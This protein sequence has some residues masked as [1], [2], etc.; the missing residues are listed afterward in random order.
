VVGGRFA[1]GELAREGGMGVVHQARDAQTGALVAIKV[2]SRV[3]ELRAQRF[4][5]EIAIL[6]QL[7]HPGIVRYLAHGLTARG[8][9]FLAMEWLEGEDLQERLRRGPLALDEAL[10]VL[11]CACDALAAA[12]ARGI[13]HRDVKP[14]NLFLP[15]EQ[16]GTVKLLDFG[17]ARSAE[18][19]A[20]LTRAGEFLGTVGYIAPEQAMGRSEIGASADVFAL[21]CVLYEC[22]TGRAPFESPHPVAVL[23]KVLCEE[24]LAPSALQPALGPDYD[25][26]LR[27]ALAKEPSQRP[28][29]AAAFRAELALLAAG[30]KLAARAAPE[31][32][33]M[34]HAE[35]KIVSV[36]LGRAMPAQRGADH[37]PLATLLEEE[38]R[39]LSLNFSAEVSPLQGGALLLVFRG[40]GE[41]N[42]RASQAAQC[43]L[44]LGQLRPELSLAVA[45]G[46]AETSG[47]IPVGV[48]IDRAAALL[49]DDA[50]SAGSV[51]VDELTL[52][53]AGPRFDVQRVQGRNVLRAL[54]GEL[55]VARPLLGK[56]TPYLGRDTEL[57]LLDLA[58]EECLREH[59]ARTV[60]VSGA[61]G[62]GKSRLLSEWLQRPR[63]SESVRVSIARAEP[64]A[65]GAGLALM[66]SLLRQAARLRDSEPPAAQRARLAEHLRALLPNGTGEVDAGGSAR[67]Q[68]VDAGGSAREQNQASWFLAELLD[69]PE[70]GAPAPLLKA[71]RDNPEIMREQTRRAL[72]SWF[73]AELARGPWLVV[74]EDLH[75]GDAPSVELIVEALTRAAQQPLCL[76]VLARP[77]LEQLYPQLA[78]KA[79]LHIRVPGLMPRAAEGLVR[80]V[81][82]PPPPADVI[83]N[84]VRTAD[85]NAFYLEELIRHVAAGGRDL[86]ETVLAMVQSRLEHL[87]PG[88]RCVLRAASV[89]GETFWAEGV[90]RIV[91]TGID[92]GQVLTMLSERE[93]VVRSPSCRYAGAR[94]YRFRHALLRDAANGMLTDRDREHAHRVAGEWLEACGEKEARLLGEHFVAGKAHERAIPWLVRASRAAIDHGDLRGTIEL[95]DRGL[96]LGV[97]G[98]ERALLL[99]SRA[100]AETWSGRSDLPGL[101]EALAL[102]PQGSA[103]WWL[104]I[105]LLT[106][107]E[108]AAGRPQE[109]A[110]YVHAALQAPASEEYAGSFGQAL[111]ILVGALVLLGRG[112]LCATLIARAQAA[113]ESALSDPIYDAFLTAARCAL[114]SVAQIAGRWQL[115]YAFRTG[116]AVAQKMHAAGAACGEAM[117]LSYFAVAATH[118]GRYEEAEEACRRA[119]A[120]AEH[121]GSGLT[122]DWAKVFLAKAQVRIGKHQEAAATLSELYT[123]GD[124]NLR[125]MLPA[126]SG[127]ALYRQGRYAQAIADAERTVAG[128]SPRLRRM[129]GCLRARAELALGRPEQA[130][131]A[132]EDALRE[133]T[134]TGLDSEIDL[135]TVCAEARAA[136]GDLA[137]A[138][139]A[140]AQARALIAA[141]AQ[142]IEDAALRQSFLERVEPCARAVQL[143]ARLRPEPC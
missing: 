24:P 54:K 138:R 141:V 38:L 15:A 33:R 93:I 137:G 61:P 98:S 133:Q 116:G 89:F 35:Q 85:G 77:E 58:L 22:L 91:E 135:F 5:R 20:A 127:E 136:L 90:A 45:T 134:S 50:V 103:P 12:H 139:A 14:N 114:A 78:R 18:P 60:L 25:D 143:G 123:S 55:E 112:E 67:E 29:D 111:L 30:K 75:W 71:A 56:R 125:Q 68:N 76:L 117:T 64:M 10:I 88:A 73:D 115:E 129:A 48:A 8:L 6:R 131:A 53:L 63:P 96:S 42:D 69:L 130:L 36:I 37:G 120:L 19:S 34:A 105:A 39:Y 26:F 74:L 41:A 70:P 128:A 97:T 52:G 16:V 1:V 43:A 13:V 79:G 72:E 62:I 2:M 28:P 32:A 102:L 17:L 107:G 118:L 132:V 81:L 9:P 27:R 4:A 3:S 113:P 140:L 108:S 84:M 124:E 44:A 40:Q 49:G 65:T 57:R 87:D 31:R 47:P 119:V 121:V 46:R 104:A 83:A 101:R 86:P 80:A 51:V 23:A 59:V 94:E 142:Q 126:I 106:L 99:L 100:H 92:T 11:R 7:D 82:D 109:A 66:Q 95:A 110:A 21:G 122:R